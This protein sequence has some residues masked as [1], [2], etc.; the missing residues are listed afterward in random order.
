MLTDDPEGLIEATA[1]PDSVTVGPSPQGFIQ[2]GPTVIH[3]LATSDGPTIDLTINE[4][5]GPSGDAFFLAVFG[6]DDVIVAVSTVI[7]P[8]P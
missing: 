5:T 4:N 3:F 8:K 7:I 2:L 1:I 6:P